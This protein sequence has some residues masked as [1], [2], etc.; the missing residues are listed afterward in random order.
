MNS[1]LPSDAQPHEAQSEALSQ[2]DQPN[3]E[4][5][6][7]GLDLADP[8]SRLA[9]LYLCPRHVAAL[10]FLVVVFVFLSHLRV[11]HTDVWGHLR[12]GEYIV[13]HRQLPRHEMFS[14]PFADQAAP[15]INYQWLAQAGAYLAFDFGRQLSAP[16]V[17][18]RL[19]GGALLLERRP[20]QPGHP[21]PAG[22]AAG[23]SPLDRFAAVRAGR[24][25]VG[26][27]HGSA[28]PSLHP[29]AAN[30]RRTRLRRPPLRPEPPRALPQSRNRC[31]PGVGAVG[32]LP[33]FV[34]R[35][36]DAARHRA[37]RPGCSGRGCSQENAGVLARGILLLGT[38][39]APRRPC[40]GR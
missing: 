15:Y 16:D 23:L 25:G 39:V 24:R 5:I 34:S 1:R 17:E 37:G 8:N 26:V 4:T 9:P 14:G 30:H 20:C 13:T 28:V 7:A 36:V 38:L 40:L 29:A 2:E 3:S 10:V 32:K 35:G 11:W 18:H 19:G 6:G 22:A 27:R 21:P 31:S 12:F 33:W